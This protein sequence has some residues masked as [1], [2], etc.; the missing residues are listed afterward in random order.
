MNRSPILKIVMIL[1]LAGIASAGNFTP[2][3]IEPAE[4]IFAVQNSVVDY[5]SGLT[6]DSGNCSNITAELRYFDSSR[7]PK[8]NQTWKVNLNNRAEHTPAIV[9]L[10][11]TKYIVVCDGDQVKM[12]DANGT[13]VWI[14]SAQ[15]SCSDTTPSVGDI[16]DDGWPDVVTFDW[17]GYIYAID[18]RDGSEL[19]QLHSDNWYGGY[20]SAVIVDVDQD[21]KTD[22]LY[23]NDNYGQIIALNGADGSVKW[24]AG[25]RCD[26]NEYLDGTMCNDDGWIESTPAVADIDKDGKLEVVA[27][28][29]NLWAFNGEDGSMLWSNTED[30]N[31]YWFIAPIIR[32]IDKDG[33]LEV[34]IGSWNWWILSFNALNGSLEWQYP[35]TDDVYS[36]SAVADIDH[37]GWDEILMGDDNGY[38]YALNHD[39][40]LLWSHYMD[41]EYMEHS[42][43]IMDA[44]NNGIW[45]VVTLNGAGGIY[46]FNGPDGEVLFNEDHID[47][48]IWYTGP[49]A[50]D[51]DNDGDLDLVIVDYCDGLYLYDT[52]S[53]S[54]NWPTAQYNYERTSYVPSLP[55]TTLDGK[56]VTNISTLVYTTDSNPRHNVSCLTKL[57]NGESCNLTWS[58]NLTGMV[59]S[60]VSIFTKFIAYN[61]GVKSTNSTKITI[62]G[63]QPPNITGVQSSVGI[64]VANISWNT[65]IDS[66]STIKL[67]K[68]TLINAFSDS[69]F[70]TNHSTNFTLP[71]NTT[72]FY[73]ITACNA[74]DK[75]STVGPF[76][77]TLAPQPMEINSL[78]CHNS[79]NWINCSA[80][81]FNEV[82]Q[83]LSINCTSEDG[84][85]TDA[86]FS[87]DFVD[88]GIN[89]V[90]QFTTK[91]RGTNGVW[92]FDN[93]D[94][95]LQDSGT[96]SVLI[97]VRILQY[98]R[99]GQ[100][101]TVLYN[102]T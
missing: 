10:N 34:V 66:N 2:H 85:I 16:N 86:Y 64:G 31:G 23:P 65:N 102:L 46:A 61:P 78:M 24:V 28:S 48:S 8:F 33:T 20:S 87:V 15:D 1:L 57:L 56:I 93:A 37:D 18:A 73:N 45:D 40:T 35:V 69:R 17:D 7:I 47:C 41:N 30:Y 12:F 4:N 39:G 88:E 95:I 52:G 14:Y 70:I 83:N 75:C 76:N 72:Y 77:F 58:L 19:W 6:C 11:G 92:T 68:S 54:Y 36:G 99:N 53:I 60:A 89:H 97:L 50:D 59:D 79:T 49:S 21:S 98:L 51:I 32:D 3:I 29:D 101:H 74:I 62:V 27:A 9:N 71:T 38:L 26:V 90:G 44:N 55:V 84:H 81:S 100:S 13:V 25:G 67:G 42:F 96:W 94:V 80:L 82:I 63:V 5:S 22:V 43:V 91:F